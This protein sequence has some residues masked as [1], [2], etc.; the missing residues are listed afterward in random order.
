MS[1]DAED[2]INR[3][4][5]ENL[6]AIDM[7]LMIKSRYLRISDEEISE[8]RSKSL[9]RYW[10]FVD[11]IDEIKKEVNYPNTGNRT[12]NKHIMNL[13]KGLMEAARTFDYEL[14]LLQ[15]IS[16]GFDY[17]ISQI[18]ETIK[19]SGKELVL[20]VIAAKYLYDLDIEQNIN[21]NEIEKYIEDQLDDYVLF[22]KELL[23]II[24]GED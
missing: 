4:R 23:K 7:Y 22:S 5:E 9:R 19:S 13:E 11:I 24:C 2:F 12:L 10:K 15:R 3:L 14:G 18:L 16:K 21:P 8:L 1:D 17:I 6:V 20:S